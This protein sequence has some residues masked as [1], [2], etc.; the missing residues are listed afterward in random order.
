MKTV[1]PLILIVF[2]CA[3]SNKKKEQINSKPA[4]EANTKRKDAILGNYTALIN[5]YNDDDCKLT[6]QLTKDE[7]CYNYQLKTTKR[8]VNGKATMGVNDFGEK[9]VVL[10]NIPW[11][12]YEGDISIDEEH[13]KTQEVEKPQGVVFLYQK[14]TLRMKNYGNSMIYYIIFGECSGKYIQLVKK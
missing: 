9:Y 3:C 8:K 10:E 4:N 14:D 13:V 7:D 11:D 12:E 2:L 5:S 6:L 1:V